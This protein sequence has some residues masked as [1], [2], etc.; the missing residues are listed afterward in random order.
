MHVDVEAVKTSH[1]VEVDGLR[2]QLRH[3]QE[4]LETRLKTHEEAV[5][6]QLREGLERQAAADRAV[7]E[8]LAQGLAQ[9]A[10]GSNNA[11]EESRQQLQAFKGT[12]E[13]HTD[14][15]A[16]A[17]HTSE[18]ASLR[19]E[20]VASAVG[21]RVSSLERK[22]AALGERLQEL[23]AEARAA[24]PPP[25]PKAAIEDVWAELS[26]LK[27]TLLARDHAADLDAEIRSLEAAE[28]DFSKAPQLDWTL[29][30]QR[31]PRTDAWSSQCGVSQLDASLPNT[32]MLVQAQQYADAY[33]EED[34]AAA[35]AALADL[36]QSLA[37][38]RAMLLGLQPEVAA[39]RE[40]P[41]LPT[42]ISPGHRQ[43]WEAM[44]RK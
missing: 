10:A 31:C 5:Q 32:A 2:A 27:A 42:L 37:S 3:Y 23:A 18:E 21:V 19:V 25:A 34:A 15:A 24:V 41:R 4:A 29:S 13:L 30:S 16:R 17:V 20:Q 35:A 44:L 38:E 39:E 9:Q 43:S 14:A 8:E 11:R 40:A 33:L 28:S 36:S 22:V 26:M 6:R 7:R 12:L 1:A